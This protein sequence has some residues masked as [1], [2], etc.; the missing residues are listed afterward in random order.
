MSCFEI[1]NSSGQV[2]FNRLTR[3]SL[4]F[5]ERTST[6]PLCL[7]SVSNMI[8]F[9][10]LILLALALNVVV[11][12]EEGL[13]ET[14]TGR[15]AGLYQEELVNQKWKALVD[16]VSKKE[17]KALRKGLA[18]WSSKQGEAA[19]EL[20]RTVSRIDA[21]P[22]VPDWGP[23]KKKD[24]KHAQF[25]VDTPL[26]NTLDL[27]DRGALGRGLIAKRAIKKG[28]ALLFAIRTRFE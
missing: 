3:R 1:W 28:R 4:E 7:C 25:L 8:L 20:V 23:P 21:V 15:R 24:L 26:A 13:V 2:K 11:G 27:V 6:E 10:F 16:W 22:F 17:R 14:T 9:P 5:T 12:L 19:V 18:H